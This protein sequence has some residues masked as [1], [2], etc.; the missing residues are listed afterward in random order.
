MKK[1]FVEQR[2]FDNGKTTAEI[3][4]T[5][6]SESRGYHDGYSKELADCDLY[7]DGFGTLKQAEQCVQDTLNA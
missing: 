2:Y 7:V 5:E 4:T 6:Q 3:L 1:Y